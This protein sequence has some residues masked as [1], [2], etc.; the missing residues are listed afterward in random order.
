MKTTIQSLLFVGVLSAFLVGAPPPKPLD[1]QGDRVLAGEWSEPV[2]GLSARL[3]MSLEESKI[4]DQPSAL[5]YKIILE[6]KNVQGDALAVSSQPRFVNVEIR[7][8]DDKLL[9]AQGYD[10]T[11]PHPSP[12]WA[13]IPGDA[14]LGVRVDMT[15]VGIGSGAAL[16]G[17]SDY[18]RFLKPGEYKVRATLTADHNKDGPNNQWVG[19]M[20][21]A[22]VSLAFDGPRQ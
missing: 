17:I 1:G 5:R 10:Q 22:P 7:D 12:Q 8:A 9:P 13:V 3:L 18:V 2:N 4:T 15:T 16:V 20:K 19:I 6:T 21:L 11:G 14:Y